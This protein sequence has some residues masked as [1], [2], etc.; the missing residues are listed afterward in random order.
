MPCLVWPLQCIAGCNGGVWTL[1]AVLPPSP[2]EPV[3][4][5]L[6]QYLAG[7]EVS[8]E[9]V[10]KFWLGGGLIWVRMTADGGMTPVEGGGWGLTISYMTGTTKTV[11]IIYQCT[12]LF[13]SAGGRSANWVL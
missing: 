4:A 10:C 11:P 1:S 5:W 2:D 8:G 7:E 9:I 3:R 12:A 6:P 13:L